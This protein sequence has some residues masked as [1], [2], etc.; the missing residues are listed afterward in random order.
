MLHLMIYRN[1]YVWSAVFYNFCNDVIKDSL[2]QRQM[3]S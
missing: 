3:N 1:L 2:I